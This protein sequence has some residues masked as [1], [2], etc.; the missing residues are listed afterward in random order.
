MNGPDDLD[1]GRALEASARTLS[2]Y[3]RA[4]GDV[5]V[6]AHLVSDGGGADVERRLVEPHWE[7]LRE[8]IAANGYEAALKMVSRLSEHLRL[9]EEQV[10]GAREIWVS[11]DTLRSIASREADEHGRDATLHGSL[12]GPTF[13]KSRRREW[14]WVVKKSAFPG[15]VESYTLNASNSIIHVGLHASEHVSAESLTFSGDESWGGILDRLGPTMGEVE[16]IR[17]ERERLVATVRFRKSVAEAVLVE[18]EV[19]G[20]VGPYDDGSVTGQTSLNPERVTRLMLDGLFLAAEVADML[21]EKRAAT[22]IEAHEQLQ[23]E[24]ERHGKDLA[25][26]YPTPTSLRDAVRRSFASSVEEMRERGAAAV[27]PQRAA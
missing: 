10:R 4:R 26:Y 16:D 11:L 3:V 25:L 12:A 23:K 9:L 15:V 8:M 1:L 17:A 27:D 20:V 13:V 21:H 7:A 22:V 5:V 19:L 14:S 18:Y 24:L 6:P 2:S